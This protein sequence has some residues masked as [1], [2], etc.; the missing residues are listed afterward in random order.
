MGG[1][2]VALAVLRPI[3]EL[4]EICLPLPP[5][6]G[7]QRPV[8]PHLAK[9]LAHILDLN[10]RP[11]NSFCVSVLYDLQVLGLGDTSSSEDG[12]FYVFGIPHWLLHGSAN[13]GCWGV[14]F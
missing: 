10:G 1:L 7:D 12:G 4:L 3:M 9:P 14:T 13:S 6:C 8:P 2:S 11:S 5:E